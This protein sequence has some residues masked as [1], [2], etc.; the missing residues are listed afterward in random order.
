MDESY[1]ESCKFAEEKYMRQKLRNY[2]YFLNNSYI[3]SCFMEVQ[4]LKKYKV[5]KFLDLRHKKFH[6]FN[7][8]NFDEIEERFPIYMVI[9]L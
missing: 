9:L 4:Q 1:L 7:D 6:L 2:R 3:K 5:S 8:R